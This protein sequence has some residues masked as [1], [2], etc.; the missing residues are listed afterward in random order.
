MGRDCSS[1]TARGQ[2]YLAEKGQFDKKKE[3]YGRVA[4]F[5]EVLRIVTD[6]RGCFFGKI[7][8]L[9]GVNV[10]PLRQREEGLLYRGIYHCWNTTTLGASKLHHVLGG[11]ILLSLS[12]P[13]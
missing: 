3:G 11:S 5:V 4:N 13:I 1:S 2:N 6:P 7:G 10:S 9:F 8:R 12:A